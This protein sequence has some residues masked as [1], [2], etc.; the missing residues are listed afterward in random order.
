MMHEDTLASA[1]SAVPEDSENV[2]KKEGSKVRAV[3]RTKK[4][5]RGEG[6][7]ERGE[8]RDRGRECD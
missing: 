7:W 3:V 2:E 6:R 4:V 5:S 1:L 8:G